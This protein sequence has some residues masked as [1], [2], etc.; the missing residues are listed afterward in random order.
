MGQECSNEMRARDLKEQL[1][2]KKE[3]TSGRIFRKTAELETEKRIVGASTGLWKVTG[4]CGGV[5]PL[6]KERREVQSTAL[7]KEQR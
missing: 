4:Q 1:R 7:E 2:L 3:G 5:G 6:R